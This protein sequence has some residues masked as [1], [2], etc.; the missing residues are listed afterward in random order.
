MTAALRVLGVSVAVVPFGVC[1]FVAFS[2]GALGGNGR[3]LGLP[4]RSTS[5]LPWWGGSTDC[6]ESMHG[7]FGAYRGCQTESLSGSKCLR[8]KDE[9]ARMKRNGYDRFDWDTATKNDPELLTAENYCRN[10]GAHFWLKPQIWCYTENRQKDNPDT[11]K[12]ETQLVWWEFCK[13]KAEH[14]C[15]SVPPHGH[16]SRQ[17]T[18]IAYQGFDPWIAMEGMADFD[19]VLLSNFLAVLT[20]SCAFAM[21]IWLKMATTSFA[22]NYS[23]ERYQA[24]TTYLLIYFGFSVFINL[25]AAASFMVYRCVYHNLV[26]YGP[27]GMW[28]KLAYV[29][30]AIYSSLVT[31][32]VM[33][34]LLFKRVKMLHIE[35]TEKEVG[36][37]KCLD[38]ATGVQIALCLALMGSGA[39]KE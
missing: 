32:G 18:N 11:L 17:E 39:I 34:R 2:T 16:G 3:L 1:L 38:R 35:Q 24:Y 20:S 31:N 8:W 14:A 21:S 22:D 25:I 5:I 33:D 37:L 4:P 29:V 36:S 27:G 30:S 6:D 13:P 15:W 19:R 23:L 26:S 7:R 10:T 12:N 28:T 9:F